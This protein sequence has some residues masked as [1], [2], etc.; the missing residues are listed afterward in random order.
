M[1]LE[2]YT[3]LQ[4][5]VFCGSLNCIPSKQQTVFCFLLL[6]FLFF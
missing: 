6:L 4:S 5:F 2:W 1:L 3:F